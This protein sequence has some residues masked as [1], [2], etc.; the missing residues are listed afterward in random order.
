MTGPISAT[1]PAGCSVMFLAADTKSNFFFTLR[2]YGQS[3][4]AASRMK[5]S[6]CK[7]L[8]TYLQ[9]EIKDEIGETSCRRT[10][11]TASTQL[12]I[13]FVKD[14]KLVQVGSNKAGVTF[15]QLMRLANVVEP[16]I[17]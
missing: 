6:D 16:R 4:A 15:D 7:S 3:A 5:D 9:G 8:G 12:D 10:T 11:K 2:D 13:M 17:S 1:D 14:G